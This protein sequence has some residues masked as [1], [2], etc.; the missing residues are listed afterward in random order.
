MKRFGTI[1]CI[2]ISMTLGFVCCDSTTE[3]RLK[4]Y[5]WRKYHLEMIEYDQVADSSWL[6]MEEMFDS[7]SIGVTSN[8]D[9]ICTY[10]LV[11]KRCYF[12]PLTDGY[13]LIDNYKIKSL[14][15]DGVAVED[16]YIIEL[17]GLNEQSFKCKIAVNRSEM[18]VSKF[19]K[20]DWLVFW[21]TFSG[22]RIDN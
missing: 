2:F 7:L 10:S 9:S 14:L 22:T 1:L 6:Y 19:P 17:F 15:D 5:E 13:A 12:Y 20:E 4:K 8:I 18:P 21:A 3:K 16:H 11:A